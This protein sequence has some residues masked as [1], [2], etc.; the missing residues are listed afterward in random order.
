MN[1]LPALSAAELQAGNNR[2]YLLE[3]VGR[4]ANDTLDGFVSGTRNL[5]KRDFRELVELLRDSDRFG[6]V[7]KRLESDPRLRADFLTAAVQSGYLGAT[8]AR[9]QAKPGVIAPP[10]QPAL[11]KN[12]PLLPQ[13]LRSLIHA[14]NKQLAAAYLTAFDRYTDAWCAAV[15][16]AAT[17]G[18]IRTLGDFSTPPTLYEPGVTDT[19]LKWN[20]WS[21]GLTGT[22]RGVPRASKALSDKLSDLRGEARAGS[23]SLD[24][25][26]GVKLKAGPAWAKQTVDTKGTATEI[27]VKVEAPWVELS[28]STDSRGNHTTSV[29][30][31]GVTTERTVDANGKAKDTFQV[32]MNEN[33]SVYSSVG[34]VN[35]GGGLK[36]T[37]K[38]SDNVELSA[39]VGFKAHGIPREYYQ[40]I[41]S[42]PSGFF[43]PM[44]EFEQ[45]VSWQSMPA[46]RRDWYA[47]QGFNPQNWSV[48]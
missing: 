38:L 4:T 42:A 10:E 26:G 33:L 47:R 8:P 19:D 24:L 34:E 9:V 17:P 23:Y 41:G 22:S 29:T 14:E 31:A 25:Q 18:A 2:G 20:G 16:A 36:G 40:D 12:D 37:A 13:E 11:V 32:K 35:F 43:G 44:P 45:Q 39:K 28:R 30:V 48:R 5:S 3:V 7:M 21:Q 15:A 27:G 46:E 1:D 6:E